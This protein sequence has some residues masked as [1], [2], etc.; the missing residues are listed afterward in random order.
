MRLST[1]LIESNDPTYFYSE[2]PEFFMSLIKASKECSKAIGEMYK[3]KK[4]LI[5]ATNTIKDVYFVSSPTEKR[6]PRDNSP[7]VDEALEKYRAAKYPTHPSRQKA[8]FAVLSNLN[9]KQIDIPYPIKL[10]GTQFFYILP[11]NGYNAWQSPTTMDLLGS[12]LV[13]YVNYYLTAGFDDPET[14]EKL[15]KLL[16]DYYKKGVNKL[17]K[18][19]ELNEIIIEHKGYYAFNVNTWHEYAIE[20]LNKNMIDVLSPPNL[21]Q[22][23]DSL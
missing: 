10:Y 20:Q 1:A 12:E 4:V 18:M 5:R 2:H 16:D 11:K 7:K 21:K 6:K 15:Q 17:G 9:K 13:T 14:K 19:V 8:S 22:I 3:N 23:R